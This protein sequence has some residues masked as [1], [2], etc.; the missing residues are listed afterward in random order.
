MV[1]RYPLV[2]ATVGVGLVCLAL[3][4]TPWSP[5]VRWV[6]TIYAGLV[7]LRLAADMV[8]EALRGQ[9][10]LDLLALIA[11]ASTLVVGEFWAALIIV[12]MLTGGE[13]LE[14]F[15]ARRAKRELSSLL[16]RVPQLAHRLGA[17]GAIT[18]LAATEVVVGDRLL[19]RPAEL[20]PVDAV[21]DDATASVDESSLTGESLPV[22][23]AA[24]DSIMSGSLNGAQA[25]IIR[26][27]AIAAES[28]YQRIVELVRDAAESKA[29][30]VRLA[31]RYAMPFT[32]V[33]LVI[34]G[35]AWALSGDPVRFAEVLV[36]ATP[37]P[38]LLAAPVAFMAGMSSAAR[39]GVVVKGA[40]TLETLARAKTVAFDKTGT[41]TLGEPEVVGVRPTAGFTE[42]ELLALVGAAEGYSSHVLAAPLVRAATPHFSDARVSEAAEVPAFG[43]RAVVDGRVVVVGKPAYVAEH[44][45]ALERAAAGP[46]EA[47]V[48]AAVDGVFAGTIVLRDAVRD[49]AG[50]TIAAL[51]GHG[52]QSFVMVT[53]DVEPTARAIAEPLGI[54]AVHAECLPAD[55]VGL[56]AATQPRP[57]VMVGDGVN[58]APVLAAADV[59]VAMGARGSTAASESADVVILLDD[60]SRVATAV[61]VARRT[62]SI[63]IQSIWLGIAISVALMLVASTGALPAVIGAGL[64]E[65]VDLVTILNALR[66]LQNPR[67]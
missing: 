16:D 67:A 35:L 58:D 61:G 15:A 63:A 31:D 40:G 32:A 41:L 47:L 43:V 45:T 23:K 9:W 52:I 11:I 59:G 48:Y 21:L 24:G 19:V 56:V 3:L 53:G 20:V 34:A 25:M 57:V 46:G 51:R 14:D 60:I 42:S 18:D 1:R 17:D 5:A 65:L 12:L 54:T 33:S 64:Q 13:A 50:A 30:M 39:H 4:A 2:F 49:N 6:A 37:C 38:L 27:T 66:A 62:V 22:E 55:K 7:A 28:Q 44:C 29:P 8:R 36:V 26:A 10:G